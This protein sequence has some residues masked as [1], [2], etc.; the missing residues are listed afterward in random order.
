MTVGKEAGGRFAADPVVCLTG[1]RADP[2]TV[3]YGRDHLHRVRLDGPVDGLGVIEEL[4]AGTRCVP[5]VGGV[6]IYPPTACA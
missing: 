4:P 1:T 3:L 6:M 5:T 2:G